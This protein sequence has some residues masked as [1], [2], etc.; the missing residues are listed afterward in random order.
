[1]NITVVTTIYKQRGPILDFYAESEKQYETNKYNGD[2]ISG[3]CNLLNDFRKNELMVDTNKVSF[4]KLYLDGQLVAMIEPRFIINDELFETWSDCIALNDNINLQIK[5]TK[6]VKHL[7][8][9]NRQN[10][11]DILAK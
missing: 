8:H 10:I 2:V 6:V 9:Y 7:T 4:E 5:D 3:C 11:I 1:M